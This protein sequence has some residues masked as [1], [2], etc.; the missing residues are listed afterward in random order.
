MKQA[1]KAKEA[2]TFSSQTSPSVATPNLNT[3]P[4]AYLETIPEGNEGQYSK[5]KLV[6]K[7]N[8]KNTVFLYH[9]GY[10][11]G[12]DPTLDNEL[13]DGMIDSSRKPRKKSCINEKMVP[14]S[15]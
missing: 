1:T 4:S 12:A 15:L 2:S 14:A 6:L 8:F 11:F 10:Y 3:S 9:G 5:K 13:K 7:E